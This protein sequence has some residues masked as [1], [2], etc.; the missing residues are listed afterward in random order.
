MVILNMT[1]ILVLSF[2]RFD[3]STARLQEEFNQEV[4]AKE[5]RSEL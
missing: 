2:A 5:T 1:T 3:L 4:A